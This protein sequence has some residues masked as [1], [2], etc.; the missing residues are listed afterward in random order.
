VNLDTQ[1]WHCWVCDSKGKRIQGLLKKLQVDVS[2]LRKVYEIYGDDYIVSSQI[3]E[4]QIELRLPKEFKSL[5]EIPTGFKPIY[6]KVKHYATLRGIRNSDII[7]YNIGYCDGGLYSGR[8][9]IP[10]YDIN[11]KLNY[12]IARSVFDDEP[13][14]YKN[15]PV[16]KNVIMFENQINWNEPIT[17]C[18]G[19]FD[20]LAVRRNAIPI[21]GKF[22]PK[23]LMDSIYERGVRNLNILLDT[24]AQDQALYYTMY[25]QKQ[26]FQIKNIIPSGKDAADIGFSEINKII[27]N[28]TE[29]NYE[30]VIL[31]KL[32]QL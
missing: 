29:T 6:K 2:K 15:P 31:Q 22:I 11:N 12:F 5:A 27:K 30:D 13:Y 28:K 3:E 9:I 1:Q 23:K 17:I 8:I 7:K 10:S 16:S 26:G 21:L 19:A 24:D 4:D 25:F 20:A 32:N 14:K 18:E